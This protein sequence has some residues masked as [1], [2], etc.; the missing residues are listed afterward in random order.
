MGNFQTFG[1]QFPGP[2]DGFL[3]EVIAE[4]PVAEHLEE[5]VVVGVEADVFEV[6]VLAAGADAFLGVGGAG[7]RHGGG[8]LGIRAPRK[9]GTNWFM[10]ALVKSRFGESGIRLD[11]GTMVCCFSRKKSRNDVGFQRWS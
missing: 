10:P 9:M 1:D 7:P 5:R 2:V 8:P 3:L 4:G 11:E 6:V